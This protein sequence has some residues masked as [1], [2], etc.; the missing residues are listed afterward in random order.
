MRKVELDLDG[1]IVWKKR[2]KQCK[3]LLHNPGMMQRHDARIIQFAAQAAGLTNYFLESEWVDYIEDYE[4][5]VNHKFKLQRVAFD[6]VLFVG[7]KNSNDFTVVIFES[8]DRSHYDEQ[9]CINN[10]WNFKDIQR[11]D[12]IKDLWAKKTNTLLIRLPEYHIFN[13]VIGKRITQ[14][15][16]MTT[17]I[18]ILKNVKDESEK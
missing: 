18:Q 8:D 11:R 17:I 5:I 10:G 3:A 7:L 1:P 9:Y 2:Y 16:K 4:N 13:G 12:K 15:E 14:E 6:H